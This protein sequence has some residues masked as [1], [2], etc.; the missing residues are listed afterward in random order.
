MNL[1]KMVAP[2]GVTTVYVSPEKAERLRTIQGYREV[3]ES[4]VEAVSEP[5][6][7]TRKPRAKKV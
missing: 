6:K 4:P 3:T 5:V 1:V 7:A 2:N